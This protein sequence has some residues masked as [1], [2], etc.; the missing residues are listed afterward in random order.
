MLAFRRD[1]PKVPIRRGC[2]SANRSGC[3]VAG[4]HATPARP[5]SQDAGRSPAGPARTAEVELIV[6]VGWR[7]TALG[8]GCG[9]VF[10]QSELRRTAGRRSLLRGELI[11]LDLFH[12]PSWPP[13]WRPS[14][15]TVG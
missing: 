10:G 13:S 2:E 5:L 3:A 9:G 14:I 7:L 6:P 12:S 1:R 15:N 8:G 4:T 11:I